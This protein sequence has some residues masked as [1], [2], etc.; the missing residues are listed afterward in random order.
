MKATAGEIHWG[1]VKDVRAAVKVSG[2][3]KRLFA[4]AAAKDLFA[5][6]LH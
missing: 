6:S 4:K 2:K 5:I 1:K 3:V